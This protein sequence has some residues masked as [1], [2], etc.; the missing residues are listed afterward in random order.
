MTALPEGITPR[1]I[2]VSYGITRQITP[3][4]TDRYDLGLE[5]EIAPG[6]DPEEASATIAHW[7]ESQVVARYINNTPPRLVTHIPLQHDAAPLPLPSDYAPPPLPNEQPLA[8]EPTQPAPITYPVGTEEVFTRAGRPITEF[9]ARLLGETYFSA[10][11]VPTITLDEWLTQSGYP[12]LADLTYQ[13]GREVYAVLKAIDPNIERAVEAAAAQ[14][15]DPEPA[16][17]LLTLPAP[18][19]ETPEETPPLTHDDALG[20]ARA[21]VQELWDDR[22][23]SL[24]MHSGRPT[25]RA[26]EAFDAAHQRWQL[27]AAHLP[28]LYKKLLGRV[29]SERARV[30]LGE[31]AALVDFFNDD[32][33]APLIDAIWPEIE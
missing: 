6:I 26:M 20:R 18:A 14:P 24:P 1:T 33:N 16:T 22:Q 7:L 8:P 10:F 23:A 11:G 17:E 28:D 21:I 25:R 9:Q 4:N 29:P 3:Y 19:Q 27:T 30:T 2:T 13:Q 31:I 12:V 32:S 5:A 15:A